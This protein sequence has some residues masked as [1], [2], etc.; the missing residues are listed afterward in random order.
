MAPFRLEMALGANSNV[1]LI[2]A[3]RWPTVSS[4]TSQWIQSVQ[5]FPQYFEEVPTS[6]R[7]L[8]ADHSYRFIALAAFSYLYDI[9]VSSY[10]GK[11]AWEKLWSL[12]PDKQQFQTDSPK[13]AI[14]PYK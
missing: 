3:Y 9:Q 14:L 2:E 13:W 10:S 5:E 1:Y 8:T 12:S 11:D 7:S 6:W 4:Q